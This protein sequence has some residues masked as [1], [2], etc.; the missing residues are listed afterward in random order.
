LTHAL[1]V[2]GC[3][4]LSTM[5]LLADQDRLETYGLEEG[6]LDGVVLLHMRA[7]GQRRRRTIEV[8]KLRSGAPI[9]GEYRFQIT[10][11]GLRVLYTP[12]L[13]STTEEGA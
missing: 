9:P 11:Q 3:T 7:S 1:K 13:E 5:R 10:S 6:L 2:F 4:T 12:G 8:S